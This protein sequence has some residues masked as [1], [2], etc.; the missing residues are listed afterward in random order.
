MHFFNM[1]DSKEYSNTR[2]LAAPLPRLSTVSSEASLGV[3]SCSGGT[4]TASAAASSFSWYIRTKGR[5]VGRENVMDGCVKAV[6]DATASAIAR[7]LSF[8]MFSRLRLP[9]LL[10]IMRARRA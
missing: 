6:H 3:S 7:Q 10:F 9:Q 4:K 1:N 5:T 8:A 2:T